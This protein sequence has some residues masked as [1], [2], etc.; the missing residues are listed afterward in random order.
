MSCYSLETN[1]VDIFIRGLTSNSYLPC[2][3]MIKFEK[4]GILIYRLEQMEYFYESQFKEI[5]LKSIAHK[6]FCQYR[7]SHFILKSI[8]VKK[9]FNINIFKENKIKKILVALL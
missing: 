5:Y 1:D 9:M 3:R 4:Y 6:F 2:K 8:N 7:S